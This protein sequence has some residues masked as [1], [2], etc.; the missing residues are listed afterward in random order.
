[1]TRG[2]IADEILFLVLMRVTGGVTHSNKYGLIVDSKRE[3]HVGVCLLKLG[4]SFKTCLTGHITED[5]NALNEFEVTVDEVREVWEWKAKGELHTLPLFSVE[6]VS[7]CV[8]EIVKRDTSVPKEETSRFGKSTDVPVSEGKFGFGRSRHGGRCEEKD[9]A[10]EKMKDKN[11][12]VIFLLVVEVWEKC[13]L[14]V[15]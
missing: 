10:E 4:F 5:G 8:H 12:V 6:V 7:L 15:V 2:G 11:C 14:S 3:D 13:F 1:M 9:G